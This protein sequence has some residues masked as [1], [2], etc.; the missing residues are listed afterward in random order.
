MKSESARNL[1]RMLVPI[2]TVAAVALV[3]SVVP[4]L[5]QRGLFV[6][7]LASV[8]LSVA[9][10]GWRG[11]L[12]AILLSTLTGVWFLNPDRGMAIRSPWD[13]ARLAI[14]I[15]TAVLIVLVVQGR[16]R[17]RR[18][19]AE[20]E[21]RLMLALEAARLGTWE[22]DLETG[23][24]WAAEGLE[25]V[26]GSA[27]SAS[28]KEYDDFFGRVHAG[29]R[30]LLEKA[31]ARATADGLDFEV[32]QRL[33]SPNNSVRWIVTRGRVVYSEA[34]GAGRVIAVSYELSAERQA[35]E[36]AQAL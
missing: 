2:V 7:L 11:A 4:A 36:A 24:F 15:G 25:R 32:Q 17:A 21:A 28:A 19:L 22:R 30:G 12:L 27:P 26:L 34:G 3:A 6:M 18:E 23:R 33:Q 9:L 1:Q 5:A 20:S 8:G 14:F 10:D 29:D 31:V 13:W 35:A 16:E